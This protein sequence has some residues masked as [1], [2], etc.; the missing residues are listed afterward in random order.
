M[1]ED[2][3]NPF[4]SPHPSRLA[5]H[6]DQIENEE[7]QRGRRL[8]V[9][10][11]VMLFVADLASAAFYTWR[12]GWDKLPAQVVRLGLS[13]ALCWAMYVGFSWARYTVIV[14]LWLGMVY[15]LFAVLRA[16][17]M[18][19]GSWELY[20]TLGPTLVAFAII[21]LILGCSESVKEF[22][23]QQRLRR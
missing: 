3:E 9:G 23:H 6:D 14:L 20:L 4:A 15:G 1:I 22:Q 7:F 16:V 5:L 2:S 12:I 19:N 21:A 8:L 18:K 11:I 17:L 10:V 13:I